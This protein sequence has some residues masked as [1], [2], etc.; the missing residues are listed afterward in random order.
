MERV[1]KFYAK[2]AFKMLLQIPQQLKMKL[3]IANFNN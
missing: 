3:H 2:F 1:F